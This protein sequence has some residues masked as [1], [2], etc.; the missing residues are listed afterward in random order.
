MSATRAEVA[1]TARMLAAAGLVEAFGHV[2][3]RAGETILLSAT[4][5]LFRCQA[6]DVVVL[7]LD[8]T[9]LDGPA[10][11][12]PLERFL[13]LAI[14]AARPDVMAICRG[15][16][17]ASV[18]WGCGTEPVPLRHGLGLLAGER[19]RV[20]DDPL[21]VS[22]PARGADAAAV[23][24]TDRCLVLRANGAL[25]TGAS[26]PEAAASL[27]ALE[28]RCQVALAAPNE[29]ISQ[30]LWSARAADTAVERTRHTTW[31]VARFDD[32]EELSC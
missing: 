17:P 4:R 21:L 9:V 19:I 14:Y 29:Q 26:L 7:A 32:R 1:A 18:A 22:D 3:A 10:D 8:G 31:F 2:S 23:L 28:E 27:Y 16:G 25:A 12:L 6:E 11:A 13:H 15:H 5:P 24:D 30:S 20:H